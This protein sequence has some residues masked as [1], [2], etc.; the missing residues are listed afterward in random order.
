MCTYT[1]FGLT[2]K[3][4]TQ[5]YFCYAAVNDFLNFVGNH[6]ASGRG[7]IPED[8]QGVRIFLPTSDDGELYIF[9]ALPGRKISD[10]PVAGTDIYSR[11]D[12]V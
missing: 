3:D 6:D 9:P 5:M 7:G 8:V 10:E 2:F 1:V 12:S 4:R 11:D